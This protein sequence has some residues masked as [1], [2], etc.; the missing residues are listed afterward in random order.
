MFQ[1]K[2]Q[3]IAKLVERFPGVT[4]EFERLFTG[5]AI[6]IDYGNVRNWS[7]KLGW[8]IDL[9]RLKQN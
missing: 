8:H 9:K 3:R 7:D 2:T 4:E 5:S 6:Y 1:A